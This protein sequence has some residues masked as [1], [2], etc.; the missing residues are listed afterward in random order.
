MSK[1][2]ENNVAVKNEYAINAMRKAIIDAS[3]NGVNHA[4][5]K[6]E[7]VAS[8]TT[9][10]RW[11]QWTI[12]VGDLR[13]ACEEYARLQGNLK[14]SEQAFIIRNAEQK[15][16]NQWRKILK[17][18]E[19]DRFHPNMFLRRSDVEKLTTFAGN[20]TY[21]HVPGKGLVSSV[22][23]KSY[24]RKM[25]ERFLAARIS[26]NAMLDDDKRDT[27]KA[28]T[29][30]VKQQERINAELNGTDEFIGLIKTEETKRNTYDNV[31][32]A[33]RAANLPESQI[34]EISGAAKFAWETAKK[35]RKDAES[36]LHTAEKTQKDL[37]EEYNAIVE[38]LDAIECPQE[39]EA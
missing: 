14:I 32:A 12:W 36:Q 25:V 33:L 16:W 21:V 35:A 5:T 7:A 26:G 1:N 18:G 22:T 2:Q 38:A 37:E 29:S 24:F 9:E 6:A 13:D 3:L 34:E 10:E 20:I 23:G 11:T 8:G 15:V 17:V 30:A 31:V 28:Y 19:E 4:I 39:E 27:L